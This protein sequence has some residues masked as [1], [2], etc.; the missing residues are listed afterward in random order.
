MRA[1][2]VAPE[3]SAAGDGPTDPVTAGILEILQQATG[4]PDLT[5]SASLRGVGLSSIMAARLT[6]EIYDRYA[7]E[8]PAE[9]LSESA[10]VARLAEFVRA[11]MLES[12]DGTAGPRSGPVAVA[13]NAAQGAEPFPLTPV[14]EAYLVGKHAPAGS[15]RVGCHHYRE[16][17]LTAPN[18]PR[19]RLAWAAVVDHHEMLRSVQTGAEQRIDPP[20]REWEMP[21]HDRE[22]VSAPQFTEHLEAVRSRMSHRGYPAEAS[23]LFAVETS[24]G[25]DGRCVVHLSMDGLVTDGYGLELVLDHWGRLYH[26]PGMTLPA[27][28]LSARDCLLALADLRRSAAFRVDREY[29]TTSAAGL[30]AGPAAVGVTDPPPVPAGVCRRRVPLEAVLTPAQ[31]AR[32]GERSVGW[33]VSATSLVLTVFAEA[34]ARMGGDDSFTLVVTTSDRMRL[35]SGTQQLVAPL[36]STML[37]PVHLTAG[38]ALATAAAAVHH[39]LWE[40]L[41]HSAVSGVEVLRAFRPGGGRPAAPPLP[42]VFTSMLDL[43]PRRHPEGFG[44]QLTYAVS[45][46]SAVALDHQMW[47]EED[48]SLRLRWDTVPELFAAGQLEALF[49][50]FVNALTTASDEPVTGGEHGLNDLQQAYYVARLADCG[51]AGPQGCQIYQSVAV[52]DLRLERLEAAWLTLVQAYEPLRSWL[53]PEGRRQVR[54]DAPTGWRIPVLDLSH[55]G[56]EQVADRMTRH[57]LRP[58]RWPLWDLRVSTSGTG[59][60]V[61]H[62]AVD[63]LVADGRSIHQILR[64]LVRAMAEPDFV[65]RLAGDPAAHHRHVAQLRGASGH[66][67]WQEH[68]RERFVA[69]PSGPAERAGSAGP[70][71]RLEGTRAGWPLADAA[72]QAQG[73]RADSVLLAALTEALDPLFAD[74]YAVEVVRWRMPEEPL[75]PGEFTALSWLAATDLPGAARAVHYQRQIDQDVAADGASGLAALRQVA[76]GRK[77]GAALVFPIVYTSLIDMSGDPLPAGA[78]TG[79]GLS[80]TPGV[81]L[82]CTVVADGDRLLYSWDVAPSEFDEEPLAA[83]FEHFGRLVDAAGAGAL[84]PAT[85]PPSRARAGVALASGLDPDTFQ[86]IVYDWN[87]TAVPFV[88][89]EPVHR[90]FE[91]QARLRPDAEAVRWPGGP[92]VTYG[93]ID[94]QANRIAWRLH[95]LG[96]GPGAVVGISL[97]RTPALVA[98]VFGVLKAGATYLPVETCLPAERAGAVLAD[99]DASAVLTAGDGP[100][101]LPDTL[102]WPVLAVD[103][104]EPDSREDAGP[105]V[106]ADL[107]LPAYVIFTSGSSGRP[108]GVAVAHRAVLNLLGWCYRTY[109]FG[110]GDLG[111]SVTSLGFDLSVFDILGLLGCGAALYLA[112]ERQ[113]RDPALLLNALTT[114]PVTFW[115]SAPTTLDQLAPLL[116]G[117]AGDPGTDL[118]RLVFLSGDY[119]PLTL[120]GKVRAVFPR[121]RLVSLGGATEATVWSNYFPIGDV[122]PDWRSIPYGKP[123]D[124]A[125]YHVLD[126]ELRPCDVGREGDLYIAG[127]CLSIGYFRRPD[128]TAERFVSDPFSGTEG[129]RMYRTGDR[130]AYRADGNLTFLGRQDDQ[131]KIRGFRVELGEIEHRLRL[132]PAISDAVVLARPD[133]AGDTKIEAYVI[134]TDDNRPTAHDVRA[135]AAL[136]LP[137]YMV[138]NFVELVGAFPATANGKLDR[139]ALRRDQPAVALPAPAGGAVSGEEIAGIFADLL[140]VATVGVTADLWDEGASSFTMVQAVTQF[141]KRYGRTVEVSVLVLEPTAGAIARHLAAPAHRLEPSRAAE[142]PRAADPSPV[143][144]PAPVAGRSPERPLAPEQAEEQ[145]PAAV[146]FF[147]VG[148]R[149]RFKSAAL[150]TRPEPTVPGIALTPVTPTPELYRRRASHHEFL[151]GP[152]PARALSELLA[153]LR[154]I[155]L[156]GRR[157][158]LYPSAGDTYAVQVYVHVRPGGVAGIDEGVYYYRP[159]R[160]ALELITPAP[161]IDRSIH[162][163]YNRP[164]YDHASFELYLIGQVH[165]IEPLYGTDASLYLALEAGYMGQLLTG[166]QA[167]CGLRLCPVGSLSFERIREH[168]GLD[169]GHRLLHSFLGGAGNPAVGAVAEQPVAIATATPM[170]ATTTAESR[171]A[172]ARPGGTAE[173]AVIGLAGRYPGASDLATFW[174]NLAAGRSAIGRLPSARRDGP[175]FSGGAH[176]RGDVP[177]GGYLAGIDVFDSMLFRISPAEARTLDPQVGLSLQA[178]W[179]C[180][181]DA[182]YTPATLREQAPRVGVFA[183][184]M[185]QDFQH[186]G[187]D[188]W[189]GGAPATIFGGT[190]EI[191]NRISHH[192][193]LTGPSVVVDTSC[194]SSLTAL[195]QATRSLRDG[196]CD[197]AVVT[198]VNLFTHRYHLDLLRDQGL[199]R[200]SGEVGAF[201]AGTSGWAPGEGVGALLLRTA[202]QAGR[203]GDLVRGIIESTSIGHVGGGGRYGS[204]NSAALAASIVRMLRLDGIEPADIGYVECAA[205]GAGIADAA[206][207]AALNEVFGATTGPPV[208]IGTLKPNLGHLEAAAGLSQLTKVLLQFD[209]GQLAPTIQGVPRSP[210]I[211]WDRVAPVPALL[212]WQPAEAGRPLRALVNATGASGTLAHA[213]LR[214][215]S[216]DGIAAS[217]ARPP[218]DGRVGQ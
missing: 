193:G 3:D 135:F 141:K 205:A 69:M 94:R 209:R 194:S 90:L 93:E 139:A 19:L 215:A 178:V 62:L 156:D 106:S 91:K 163:F 161:S 42:V 82:D 16:F 4:R 157:R 1:Q 203:A 186:V 198:G 18:V 64:D 155:T 142:P 2:V 112:D 192:F 105:V 6:I 121:A 118:L 177:E 111:L 169:S 80:C 154:P 27:P 140:G 103:R 5:D 55:P 173:V 190:S 114:E 127:E 66:P 12:S 132:H 85:G 110:P 207:I 61:L 76:R 182:G 25:P 21:H 34:L 96:I 151:A 196:E 122:D 46:T 36:T 201:G 129:D 130:A 83:A 38:D 125:R 120:P 184:A 115:N 187:G 133:Q 26:D 101:W 117:L 149:A 98:A 84:P 199:L 40:G 45:Q 136:A 104:A 206:E 166:E 180:L 65:P 137:D 167:A 124:N 195:H 152:V 134:G 58:D 218:H 87:D 13:P 49:A 88:A 188:E 20:G 148:D 15:D 202:E 172:P 23:P 109:G 200:G 48:G 150:G 162:V 75:R 144:P 160:H 35:P 217:P 9:W 158:H 52:D 22:S 197:A 7:V 33:G 113:Q 208:P 29:W 95:D 30:P 41:G 107:A 79:P 153:R 32:L 78:T 31:W 17:E 128:L 179:E 143:L 175:G 67:G 51:P 63:L 81:S 37:L 68:W 131:V 108:K 212:D 145:A 59:P 165:G 53:T 174:R 126:E 14:Q 77:A 176:L 119:T 47:E 189:R 146:D 99:A 70:R 10:T 44:G 204:A 183:G 39:R 210:L 181:E 8:A 159:E 24:G 60:A 211:T 185:W 214:S 50:A 171:L 102:P 73:L 213:V 216:T 100:V 97:P 92:P 191:S 123:I 56:A 168:F 11:A 116:A 72:I 89:E 28:P 170:T 86:R 57:P 164:L 138:P 74:P 147:S 43:R 54:P 71:V